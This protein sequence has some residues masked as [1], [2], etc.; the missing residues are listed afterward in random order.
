MTLVRRDRKYVVRADGWM[1]RERADHARISL[2][3]RVANA[4]A[5][6]DGNIDFTERRECMAERGK[7]R[8][9]MKDGIDAFAVARSGTVAPRAAR[10]NA[11]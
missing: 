10:F 11:Q 4:P 1:W 9:A 7:Q 8:I 5:W 6:L 3:F 2:Q